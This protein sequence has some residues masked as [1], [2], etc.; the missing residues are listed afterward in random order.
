M[1]TN[2]GWKR[3]DLI[4]LPNIY[5]GNHLFFFQSMV[6]IPNPRDVL[7]HEDEIES[8]QFCK[9]AKYMWVNLYEKK[10]TS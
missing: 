8:Y 6:E 9:D 5:I 7:S 1:G 10:G 2:K 3:I 4:V